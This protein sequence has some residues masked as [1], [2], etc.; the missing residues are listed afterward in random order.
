[1]E[2][3][4]TTESEREKGSFEVEKKVALHRAFGGYVSVY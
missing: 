1:M 3:P 2:G 4:E